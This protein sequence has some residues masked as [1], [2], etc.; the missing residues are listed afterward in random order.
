MSEVLEG[1]KSFV[2]TASVNKYKI[3]SDSPE[4]SGRS[5]D[6]YLGTMRKRQNTFFVDDFN[7][8]ISH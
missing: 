6:E 1:L 8:Y 4:D 3:K 7:E 5:A 2:E